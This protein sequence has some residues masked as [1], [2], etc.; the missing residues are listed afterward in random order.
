MKSYTI[1]IIQITRSNL[2]CIYTFINWIEAALINLLL[3]TVMTK[4]MLLIEYPIKIFL[5]DTTF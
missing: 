1:V 2:Y 5:E 4:V 3:Y